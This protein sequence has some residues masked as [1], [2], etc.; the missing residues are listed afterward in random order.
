MSIEKLLETLK[1]KCVLAKQEY[2][3]LTQAIEVL[4]KESNFL[5]E[6]HP[7]FDTI[8]LRTN[9]SVAYEYL[10]KINRPCSLQELAEALKESGITSKAKNF[11]NNLGCILHRRNEFTQLENGMWE[12]TKN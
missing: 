6:S 3:R 12:L 4:E 10:K 1:K 9:A 5:E 2:E 11:K 7:Y 8:A